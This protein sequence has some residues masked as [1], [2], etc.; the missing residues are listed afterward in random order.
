MHLSN[1]PSQF[2]SP[3][4][5][6]QYFSSNLRIPGVLSANRF[7]LKTAF[8]QCHEECIEKLGIF[9]GCRLY[10]YDHQLGLIY[11]ALSQPNLEYCSHTCGNSRVFPV[12]DKLENKTTH[13]SDSQD[14]DSRITAFSVHCN[15]RALSLYFRYYH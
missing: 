13:F 14:I 9:Y 15:V 3:F 11:K 5:G 2:L 1:A 6:V 12:F 4:K 10:F 7:I 8:L